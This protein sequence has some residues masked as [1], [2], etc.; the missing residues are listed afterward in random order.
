MIWEVFEEASDE[1]AVKVWAL[2]LVENGESPDP[3][4]KP[5]AK[6]CW[7]FGKE[8]GDP[9]GHNSYLDAYRRAWAEV[10]RLNAQPLLGDE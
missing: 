4:V 1:G 9:A 2:Y 7:F 10:D 8:G 3:R 6:G 5:F